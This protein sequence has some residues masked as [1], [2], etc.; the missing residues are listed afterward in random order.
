MFDKRTLI[1]WL[2]LE[3][4]SLISPDMEFA[5]G[6]EVLEQTPDGRVTKIRLR[7]VSLVPKE[8]GRREA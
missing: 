8:V 4:E 1:G 3:D 5:M 6:Y 7:E 2:Y